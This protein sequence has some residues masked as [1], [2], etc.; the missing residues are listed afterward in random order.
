MLK[1]S[2]SDYS[3]A[4][5]L[6]QGRINVTGTGATAVVVGGDRTNK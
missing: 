1:S 3:N 6:I 2:L 4:Y 5:I